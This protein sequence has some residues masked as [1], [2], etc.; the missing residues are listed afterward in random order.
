M[1]TLL[2]A[3]EDTTAN[4][5]AWAL[6][7]IATDAR[8]QQRLADDAQRVLGESAACPDYESLK[9]LDLFEAVCTEAG[10]LR[11]VASISSFEPLEDVQLNDLHVPAGTTVFF[12]HRPAM[13]DPRNFAHP[14]RFDVDR[15][16][17]T[18]TDASGP[19]DSAAHEP[20][21]CILFGA[22]PR[23]CPG[24]Y[25]ACVEMRLVLSMLLARFSLELTVDPSS[26][27]EIT[28]FA[29]VPDRMPIRLTA[30]SASRD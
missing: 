8:L 28:A 5:I 9:Q 12:I 6:L 4:A 19:G 24:R 23:V 25:L 15:W 20:R 17:H 1:L 13:L 14:E 21:A 11:P 7:Y 26:I 2:L 10:R 18:R 27:R 3:G 16:L 30:R 29:M 22:G